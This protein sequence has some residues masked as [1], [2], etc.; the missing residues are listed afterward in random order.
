M[1][2]VRATILAGTGAGLL[3]MLGAAQ[4]PAAFAKVMPGLWELSGL[5]GGRRV[6]QCIGDLMSFGR[7]EHRARACSQRVI[8]DGP[9]SLSIDYKCAPSEF[10][11]SEVEVITPRSLRIET[12]GISRNLPF[13]YVVQARRIGEC[14]GASPRH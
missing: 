6:E 9:T 7:V 4:R 3:L 5:P 11:R 12:Q 10:G 8:R 2:T 13:S 14:R 1:T